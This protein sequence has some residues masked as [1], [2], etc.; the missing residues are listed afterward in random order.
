MQARRFIPG[1]I[2]NRVLPRG[3]VL[4]EPWARGF[5]RRKKKESLH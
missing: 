4:D 2:D 5:P 1:G 3:M